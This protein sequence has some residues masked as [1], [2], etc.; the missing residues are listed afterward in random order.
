MEDSPTERK[1]YFIGFHMEILLPRGFNEQKV[2]KRW[3]K[4]FQSIR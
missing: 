4:A 2:N 3:L 1:L